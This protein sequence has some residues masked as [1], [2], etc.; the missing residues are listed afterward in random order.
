LYGSVVGVSRWGRSGD[1][2]QVPKYFLVLKEWLR[3]FKKEVLGGMFGPL[4]QKVTGG[5]KLHNWEG[6][7]LHLGMRCVQNC[8]EVA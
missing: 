3:V 8:C 2:W 1:P 7:S 6:C 4:R 5:R